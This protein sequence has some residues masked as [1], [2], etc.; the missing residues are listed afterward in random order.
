[1]VGGSGEPHLPA[2]YTRLEYIKSEGGY[3]DTGY[4]LQLGDV[5]E[6]DLWVKSRVANTI[7]YG[8]RRSG[9][10]R[11][12]RQIIGGLNDSY[13]L[14]FTPYMYVSS[15]ES[16]GRHDNYIQVDTRQSIRIE[17]GST[18]Y[19]YVDDV[20]SFTTSGTDVFDSNDSSVYNPCIFTFNALGIPNTSV[21]A[22]GSLC[23]GYKVMR[24][25]NPFI[26]L[27]PAQR[28][29]D[30]V[31]GIYDVIN[32]V[33]LT[34]PN[35]VAFTS[36]LDD[37][38]PLYGIAAWYGTI[39]DYRYSASS[40]GHIG[41]GLGNT[42]EAYLWLQDASQ[43]ASSPNSSNINNKP[44]IFSISQGDS[45]VFKVKNI[46]RMGNGNIA[47]NVRTTA[48]GNIG[49]STGEFDNT[50]DKTITVVSSANYD[51]S[52]VY[53]FWRSSVYRAFCL[54]VELWVNNVRYI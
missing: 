33:F 24:N 15:I 13:D 20:L 21:I 26:W 45:L 19:V 4:P 30:S 18:N 36:N 27:I 12:R 9:T 32:D 41:C 37:I 11:D 7:Y 54:D 8:V 44:K 23:Y 52:G 3:I 42:G 31:N 40:D 48:N 49:V 28:D 29:L 38:T 22:K 53:M 5:V 46:T 35:N 39:G 14:A 1:M 34:S 47:L 51:V 43:N 16:E 25:G 2:G 50:T 17:T 10:V 6:L